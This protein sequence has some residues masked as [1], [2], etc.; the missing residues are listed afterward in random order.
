MDKIKLKLMIKI[1][2]GLEKF[3]STPKSKKTTTQV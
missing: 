1:E 3:T 2:I